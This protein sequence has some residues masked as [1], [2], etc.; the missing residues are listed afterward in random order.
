MALHCITLLC[1]IVIYL[2][3]ISLLH[4]DVTHL[5]YITRLFY[6]ENNIMSTSFMI[7]FGFSEYGKR[8]KKGTASAVPLHDLIWKN[9]ITEADR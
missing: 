6:N 5:C 2:C 1:I 7:F 4:I 9:R 3:Y 8:H